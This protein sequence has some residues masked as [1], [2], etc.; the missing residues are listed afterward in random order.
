MFFVHCFYSK[1][2]H[3]RSQTLPCAVM[4]CYYALNI[5]RERIA[6]ASKAKR[7]ELYFMKLG[8]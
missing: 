2:W 7:G 3:L 5:S 4:L 6:L 1:L 8:G